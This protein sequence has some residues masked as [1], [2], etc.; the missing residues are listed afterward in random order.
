MKRRTQ[1]AMAF[2]CE[3]AVAGW[4]GQ[5]RQKNPKEPVVA[6]QRVIYTLLGDECGMQ[7]KCFIGRARI[8]MAWERG[9]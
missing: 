7:R 4:Q 9:L 8:L 2:I 5:R 3:V 6:G 1:F